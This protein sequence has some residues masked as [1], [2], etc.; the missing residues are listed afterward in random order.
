MIVV[1]S[2]GF[3][4]S[5]SRELELGHEAERLVMVAI[6]LAMWRGCEVGVERAYECEVD[7]IGEAI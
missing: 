1:T 4:S 5:G 3:R 7:E 2:M 6:G